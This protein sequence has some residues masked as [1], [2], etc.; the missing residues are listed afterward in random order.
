LCLFEHVPDNFP[1]PGGNGA[2]IEIGAEAG[3]VELKA[4]LPGKKGADDAVVIPVTSANHR[5]R[6]VG[7]RI[8]ITNRGPQWVL[9]DQ[10]EA[11]CAKEDAGA[12]IQGGILPQA[13]RVLT[14]QLI[15]LPT[16]IIGKLGQILLRDMR[17]IGPAAAAVPQAYERDD[18]VVIGE[19][20]LR[21]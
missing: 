7:K 2:A 16:E 14:E 11:F 20:Y 8:K 17:H 6:S 12:G 10:A 21:E 18:D 19:F 13:S 15:G 9:V 4:G 3:I 1:L 5:L